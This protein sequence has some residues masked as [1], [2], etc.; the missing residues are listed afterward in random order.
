MAKTH[1]CTGCGRIRKPTNARPPA[2][3]HCGGKVRATGKRTPAY[4]PKGKART[5]K[6]TAGERVNRE[7]AAIRQ[8]HTERITAEAIANAKSRKA[9]AITP[10][11]G[12]PMIP[13]ASTANR[14][15]NA[16][17]AAYDRKYRS[18]T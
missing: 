10:P 15:S 14:G 2:C 3:E 13:R 6:V 8:A 17:N 1:Q 5:T 9:H 18:M 11:A 16:R 12:D 7:C 4:M